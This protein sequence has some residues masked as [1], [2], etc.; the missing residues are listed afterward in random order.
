M[1]ETRPDPTDLTPPIRLIN[2]YML[3]PTEKSVLA[4]V[5]KAFK[6]AL[7]NK[8]LRTNPQRSS[9]FVSELALSLEEKYGGKALVQK[10][11]EQGIKRPGEWLFD[12]TVVK[13]KEVK[14]EYK[15]RSAEVINKVLWAVESE[16]STNLKEFLKD[17]AKL[18]HVKSSAYLYIAGYNQSTKEARDS[19]IK[20]QLALARELV[21]EQRITE[22][23]FIVFVPSPAKMSSGSSLWDQH[24]EQE[25]IKELQCKAIHVLSN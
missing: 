13:K 20:S 6:E 9:F 18:L 19:Y 24:T 15:Q 11:N 12:I 5:T 8:K 4:L 25:L 17:F 2:N 1:R 21:T 3:N 7:N 10:T 23:F 14:T 16:F 22:P